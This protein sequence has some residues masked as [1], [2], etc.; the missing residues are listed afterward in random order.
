MV[1]S[2]KA[3]VLAL[4]FVCAQ[5]FHDVNAL[6]RQQE[7]IAITVC[8][9][10]GCNTKASVSLNEKYLQQI[11]HVFKINT[12]AIKER[13]NIRHAIALLETITGNNLGTSL[14][15]GKNHDGRELSYQMDCIDEST[16]STT[17][18]NLM[19]RQGLLKF[20][21]VGERKMRSKW[22]FDQHWT[23]VI[24]DN[25]T[26]VMYAVDSW[27]LDNGQLPYIQLLEHWMNRRNYTN[28][29]VLP[30]AETSR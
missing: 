24:T 29:N 5:A 12:S 19:K 15:I 4:V 18:L 20:H 27:Y 13:E 16:N 6:Q 25:K 26:L 14:D 22:V 10:F 28:S 8:F 21:D 11:R 1:R 23:A 30:D 17:Y 7:N 3:Y 9:D 2:K